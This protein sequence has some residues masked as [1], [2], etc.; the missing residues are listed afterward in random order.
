M[1]LYVVGEKQGV[2][3]RTRYLSGLSMIYRAITSIPDPRVIPNVEFTLDRMDLPNLEP[4]RPGR[5]AWAWCRNVKDNDTWVMPDFNGWASSAWEEV[6]GYRA[7]REKSARY[8]NPFKDKIKKAIWRG[9]L[10]VGQKISEPRKKLLA[11]SKD[12]PWSD[13]SEIHWNVHTNTVPMDQHCKW[14][15]GIHTEG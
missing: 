3:D 2:V 7:L 11:A 9:Q 14:Q 10:N 15:F 6:G 4:H 5:I 12:K 13:I 8:L 1:Q